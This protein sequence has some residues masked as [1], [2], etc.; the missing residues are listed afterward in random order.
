MNLDVDKLIRSKELTPIDVRLIYI[1][2]T[3]RTSEGYIK[4]NAYLAEVTG[5]SLATIE[6]RLKH[7][8]SKGLVISTTQKTL[9]R[10]KKHIT[11]RWLWINQKFLIKEQEIV[12][13]SNIRE[14]EDLPY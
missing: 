5:V 2:H 14:D 8:Y 3:D 10:F 9:N 4:G 1:I 6:R 12:I 13:K 11:K 7:L